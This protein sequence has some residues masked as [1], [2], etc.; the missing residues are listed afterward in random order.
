MSTRFS[1]RGLAEGAILA[2]LVALFTLAARYLPLVGIASALVCPLPLTM[3]VVRHGTRIALLAA[4]VAAA[5]GTMVGGPITGVTIAITFAPLGIALGIGIQRRLSASALVLLST[6]VITVS[7]LINLAVTLLVAGVNP[8]TLTITGMQQGQETAVRIYE[9]LGMDRA[10][11]EQ[12]TGPMRQMMD[13]LP[14]LIPLLI[15]VG[16]AST[17]YINLLV[18]RLVLRKFGQEIPA[19]PPVS[20]W[21]VPA[22][23]IWM[24]PVGLLLAWWSRAG[25]I[26]SGVPGSLLRVL[27]PDDVSAVF[28]SAPSRHPLIETAGLN[29]SILAQMIFS[30]LGLAVGWVWLDRYNTPRWFRWMII[31]LAFATPI[32]GAAAFFLGLADAAFDLRGRWRPSTPLRAP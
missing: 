20:T 10:Q 2:A 12:A 13:L 18:G 8:Y 17:A 22:L 16:G 6:V 19:L 15:V 3:L 26:D 30:L 27:P 14:R 1:V 9:R 5:I 7:L 23:L 24:L 4:L 31:L 32:I 11:I 25:G 29:L 21:R 28:R